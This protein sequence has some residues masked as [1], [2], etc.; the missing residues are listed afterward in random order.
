M[1]DPPDC[2]LY[3]HH[4]PSPPTT[5]PC[6]LV[7]IFAFSGFPI[8]FPVVPRDGPSAREGGFSMRSLLGFTLFWACPGVGFCSGPPRQPIFCRGRL[9]KNDEPTRCALPNYLRFHR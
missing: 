5:R 4:P 3:V 1:G 2:H 6:N 9:K 7:G 8:F